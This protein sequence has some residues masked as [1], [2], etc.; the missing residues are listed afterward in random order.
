MIDSLKVKEHS[1]Q[2]GQRNTHMQKNQQRKEAIA[3]HFLGKKA[4]RHGLNDDK[5]NCIKQSRACHSNVLGLFIP[6]QPVATKVGRE[7]QPKQRYSTDPG[8]PACARVAFQQQLF[9]QMQRYGDCHSYRCK[10]M[11]A[12]HDTAN[13]ILFITDHF[14]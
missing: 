5:R 7:K 12:A 11:H 2:Q 6:H 14:H 10:T 1:Q 4:Q 3:H 13:V 8:K 9:D